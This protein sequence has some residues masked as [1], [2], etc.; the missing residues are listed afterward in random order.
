[1]QK[2]ANH[3]I[4]KPWKH[5]AVAAISIALSYALVSWAIDS[6]RLTAYFGSIVLGIVAIHHTFRAAKGYATKR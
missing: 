2:A 5:L 3:F 6:G 1:M 4:N